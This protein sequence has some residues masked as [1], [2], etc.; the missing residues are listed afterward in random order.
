[1]VVNNVTLFC[2]LYM[3]Y[4]GAFSLS[5]YATIQGGVADRMDFISSKLNNEYFW[6]S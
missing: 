6:S 4:A 2:W 3:H 1:M 5:S